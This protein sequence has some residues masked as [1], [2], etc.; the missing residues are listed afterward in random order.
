MDRHRVTLKEIAQA[1]N[2]SIGTVDR[3]LNNRPGVNAESKA[4]VLQI[5]A[6]LGYRPNRF[7]SALSRRSEIRICL[8]F[9]RDPEAFYRE[10]EAGIDRAAAELE[11]YGVCVEKLRFA[12]NDSKEALDCI[13]RAREFDGAAVNAAGCMNAECLSEMG[14]TPLITFNTDCPTAPRAFFIGGNA[15]Q[16]GRVAGELMQML[17][18]DN[19]PVAVLGNFARAMPF[20][21]RFGG[22]FEYMHAS[23]AGMRVERCI[24]C[25]GDA[26]SASASL[27]AALESSPEL[28]GVFATGYSS[29]IGAVRALKALNRRDVR[30]I[31]YDLTNETAAALGEGWCDLLLHQNPFE[32]GYQAARLLA[33]RLLESWLPERRELYL[34]TQIVVRGNMDG[35]LNR[36]GNPFL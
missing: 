22:F 4:R 2:V 16:S 8:A 6:S 24:E 19:G 27:I 14:S 29:T 3:A 25:P 1:A 33:R 7:A 12:L 31:G 15:R 10:I 5:A 18:N 13:H 23:G 28:Q 35:L 32:Q 34:D 36:R 11:D 9:P 30:L 17:V 26:E 21:E 20:L